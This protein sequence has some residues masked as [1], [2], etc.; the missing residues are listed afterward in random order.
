M[1]SP[2][3]GRT[4]S[5]R[6]EGNFRL[7]CVSLCLITKC[8]PFH[9]NPRCYGPSSPG[10]AKAAGAHLCQ[11]FGQEPRDAAAQARVGVVEALNQN[12]CSAARRLSK[13]AEKDSSSLDFLLTL[14]PISQR[15]ATAQVST[16]ARVK[17]SVWNNQRCMCCPQS[18]FLFF[19]LIKP[20]FGFI[21]VHIWSCH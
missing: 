1:A 3:C 13:V 17:E 16:H 15:K 6:L 21:G 5:Q 2:V 18:D 10:E 8:C 20:L 9:S 7:L 12:Y 19:L 14:I 11:V 4:L